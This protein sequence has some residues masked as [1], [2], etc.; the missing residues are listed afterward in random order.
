MA[1]SAVIWW[2]ITSGAAARTAAITAS[3]SSPSRTAGS[4]PVSRS[5]AT[6]PGDRGGGGDLVTRRDK[7]G[8]EVLSHRSGRS[9][10]ENSHDL[11]LS[12]A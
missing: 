4:A 8:Y 9:G 7:P 2:M 3:R 11:L 1:A 10:D 6:L 12:I 5:G